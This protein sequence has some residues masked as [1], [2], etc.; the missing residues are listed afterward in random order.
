[1]GTTKPSFFAV[2]FLSFCLLTACNNSSDLASS[3]STEFETSS[4]NTNYE[5]PA[6]VP[7]LQGKVKEI[8]GNEVTIFKMMSSDAQGSKNLADKEALPKNP[9]ENP[10]PTNTEAENLTDEDD[11]PKKPGGNRLQLSTETECFM[12]P[13]GIPIITLKMTEGQR[14]A[15]S[16]AMTEI[17]KDSILKIWKAEDGTVEFVQLS[18][19][20]QKARKQSGEN[21][22]GREPEG[23]PGGGIPGGGGPRE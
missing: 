19:T 16:V 4:E 3:K 8:I 7:D 13:V 9:E 20:R 18:G 11:S 6:R 5:L 1:M 17:T 10:P 15:Q 23:G 14:T 22:T 21:R 2:L 12:I